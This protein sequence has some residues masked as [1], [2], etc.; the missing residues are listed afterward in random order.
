[1]FD[2][3][4]YKSLT[5]P[6]FA[7][8]NWIFAPMWGFLYLTILISLLLYMTKPASNKKAGYIYFVIQL[9]LNLAWSPI[10]FG[11]REMFWAFVVIILMDIFVFLTIKKFYYVS[12]P[13]GLLLVPYFVWILFATYLNAGYLFL[14]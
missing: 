2:S 12:K 3:I 4:W 14:N 8:P 11:L 7:P 6:P 9:A 1:M 10:F 13:A 5:K